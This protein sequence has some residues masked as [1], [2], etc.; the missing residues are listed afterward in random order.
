MNLVGWDRGRRQ[1]PSPVGGPADGNATGW[2][3]TD[4]DATVQ[5]FLDF[6]Q[7]A[8]ALLEQLHRVY[9]LRVWMI[10]RSEPNYWIVLQAD[11][12]GYGVHR[13]DLLLW[14][15]SFRSRLS[16]GEG[17]NVALETD[18]TEVTEAGSTRGRMKVG[19]YVAFPLR[20]DD[21]TL[22]GTLCGLDPEPGGASFDRAAPEL[23]FLARVL[24][25]LL[26]RELDAEAIHDAFSQLRHQAEEDALTG[27]H[28]RHGWQEALESAETLCGRLGSSASVLYVDL[29]ELKETN[30]RLGHAAGDRLL[31]GAA[32]AL[33]EATRES[34]YLARVGGDEFG[35]L[36]MG[37][38]NE[39][40]EGLSR[41]I[42]SS[43]EEAGINAS[44]GWSTRDPDGDLWTT[45][46][47][48]DRLMYERKR[49]K[50]G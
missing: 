50:G 48:A 36:A 11:D 42:M 26:V 2:T 21:G 20:R 18:R 5:A 13:G 22:L 10:T 4:S 28:N 38:N 24:A 33:K 44:V 47:R 23:E 19:H 8:A 40:A 17:P 46:T 7:A 14:P 49:A 43:L 45:V 9:P 30:D 37:C 35:V 29:D 1:V 15:E 12:R 3:H 39:M 16:E 32:E 41:R 34:D 27:V 25:S 6:E 31:V